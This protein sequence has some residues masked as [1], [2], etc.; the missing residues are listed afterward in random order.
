MHLTRQIKIKQFIYS[1]ANKSLFDAFIIDE[2]K[3]YLHFFIV[4]F[5]YT[6]MVNNDF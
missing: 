1:R 6:N 5:N 2:K 4:G 3:N